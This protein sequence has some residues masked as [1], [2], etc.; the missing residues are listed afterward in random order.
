MAKAGLL[1]KLIKT[2]RVHEP[3][4]PDLLAAARTEGI[5]PLVAQLL[6]NRGLADVSA[7]RAFLR[8]E[9]DPGAS[10]LL[11]DLGKAVALLRSALQRQSVIA[12]YG[13]YDADGLTAAALLREALL[14]VGGQVDIHIPQRNA[15]GYGLNK[16]ALRQLRER[17]ADLILTADCGIASREEVE[18][19]RQ[20]G[21]AVIVTDHHELHGALPSADAIVNPK[22]PDSGYPYRELAGV[23]VAYKLAESLVLGLSGPGLWACL[24]PSLLSLL[25]IGTIADS[26]PLIGENRLLVQRGLVAL[27]QTARPGLLALADAAGLRLPELDESDVA[28]GLAPR[29]NAAGRVA[30]AR[31]AFQLLVAEDEREAERLARTLESHNQERQRLTERCLGIAREIV[32]REQPRAPLLLVAHETFTPGVAGLIAAKLVEEFGRPALAL[33][34]GPEQCRGSARSLEGFDIGWALANCHALLERYGGHP[35]AAGLTVATPRL[36]DLRERLCSLAAS[37][38]ADRDLAPALEIDATLDLAAANRDLYHLLREL[39]PH[40]QGNPEPV[41]AS[42]AWCSECRTVGRDGSHLRLKLE[43][44]SGEATAVGFG[45]GHLARSLAGEL[46]VA[47]TLR[48]NWWNG[49]ERLEL[50]L[51]DVRPVAIGS[52][53]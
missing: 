8:P 14:G 11:R 30:D 52:R 12:V 43:N 13:D 7:M 35:L 44:G 38:L 5:H 16:P 20:L 24:E 41:F 19:A 2:W 40:G 21:L 39:P 26:V 6:F 42:R 25:A 4:P 31:L 46:D 17:G 51:K 33:Q 10:Y 34:W 9:S 3:A 47:Y 49:V 32:E 23:G 1:A 50:R 28:F 18:Y 45:L 15:E 27:R 53:A 48:L 29:L 36:A 22:R 37:A